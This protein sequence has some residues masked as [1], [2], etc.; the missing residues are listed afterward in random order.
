M[1]IPMVIETTG[2]SERAYDI[3]SRLL[4]DRIV[5]LGDAVDDHTASLVCAQLLFLESEDPEKE[6][7]LYINS[8]G[9]VVTAGL[10]IYDTMRYVTCPIATL[11]MGQ[12]ASMGALLLTAGTSGLRY[13]LP[14]SRIMIHQ[15]SG[16][17][18]GQATDIEIHARETMRVKQMLNEIMAEHSGQS[19]ERIAELTER[20]NF[21]SAAEAA[22]LGLIDRVLTSRD[23]LAEDRKD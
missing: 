1:P 5:L 9:G 20:D 22:E 8:P 21:M 10:A 13:A 2:R 7:Y 15:P 6:I 12:A 19:V 17:F 14:H 3:Y 4:K 16:G 23:D 11:C 18:R